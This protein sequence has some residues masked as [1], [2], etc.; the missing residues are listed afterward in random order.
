MKQVCERLT[1]LLTFYLDLEGLKTRSEEGARLGYTGKQIIH[2]SQISIVQEA[3][4]PSEEKVEWATRLLTEFA[5]FQSEGKVFFL[6]F[7][8]FKLLLDKNFF[9]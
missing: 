3:F 1:K 9:S 2:P 4:L 5:I 7:S 8:N 6:C